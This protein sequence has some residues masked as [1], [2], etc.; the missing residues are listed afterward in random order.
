MSHNLKADLLALSEQSKD[1]IAG[2]VTLE[3]AEELNQQLFGKNG[4]L[5]NALKSL[6]SLPPE[7]R[8]ELGALANTVKSEL[9]ALLDA[10]RQDIQEQLSSRPVEFD[11]TL[12]GAEQRTPRQGSLHPITRQIYDLNEAFLSMGFEIYEGP[13]ISSEAFAFD[14][15]NFPDFHPARENMD[16]YWLAGC[17]HKKGAERLCLRPH[18]TGASVRYMLDHKPPF[19]FVYPGRVY[20][21]ESTD[22]SHERAFHQYEALI[23]DRE[24]PFSSVRLLVDSILERVF[25]RPVKTR[26]RSGFFPF[27]EPGFEIDMQC[28]ICSGKGCSV[29]KQ[30]GW[31]EMMPGGPPHPNVLKAGRID[32]EK[33]QGAYIN[34][35]LDRIVMM[36]HSINDLRLFH[37]SDL[38]FLNQFS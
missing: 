34:I 14:A 37:S 16:T 12:P 3:A 2:L 22:A 8:K 20:R 18:L 4:Q 19:R 1:R 24:V 29:C 30:V 6:G 23:V 33:W 11:L 26:M 27:V 13:E 21:N 17:E 10:K 15:L 31:L 9:T 25:G 38:R 5:K 7:D 36:K 35:G 28:L 32:P